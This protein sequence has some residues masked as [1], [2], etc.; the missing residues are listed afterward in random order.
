MYDMYVSTVKS[1]YWNRIS[2][3]YKEAKLGEKF[4]EIIL[5][6]GKP[7]E[8]FLSYTCYTWCSRTPPVL[9]GWHTLMEVFQ[10][11]QPERWAI[12]SQ[13]CQMIADTQA[14][15]MLR[16]INKTSRHQ[17]NTNMFHYFTERS[18]LVAC[19]TSLIL[20]PQPNK[21]KRHHGRRKFTPLSRSQEKWS[22]RDSTKSWISEDWR[23]STQ[24][25]LIG[26]WSTGARRTVGAKD[27]SCWWKKSLPR[28]SWVSMS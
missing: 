4:Y 16:E 5:F 9:Q 7:M 8:S 20:F 14:W 3:W 22:T 1:I 10:A 19:T 15:G 23:F 21:K 13:K 28:H 12:L 17:K 18:E 6:I 26:A 27:R 24:S 25:V 2:Y 11:K